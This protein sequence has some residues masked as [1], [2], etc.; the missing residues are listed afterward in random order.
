MIALTGMILEAVV[1]VLLVVTIAYCIMLD[2]R[3][4]AFKSE[5]VNL[6]GLV[7]ELSDATSNA[8]LA[9]AGLKN[10]ADEADGELDG[11]LKKARSLS[12]ELAFM[13]E[14]GNSLA[15]KLADPARRGG[16]EPLM[17]ARK[18]AQPRESQPVR[19]NVAY[20]KS[21]KRRGPAEK[22]EPAFAN[23][24][25]PAAD[26]PLHEDV[27]RP[28]KTAPMRPRTQ[29]APAAG[30]QNGLA[31]EPARPLAGRPLHAPAAAD[32]AMAPRAQETGEPDFVSAHEARRTLAQALKYAR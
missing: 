9:V 14:T 27:Q 12:E 7:A 11:K 13:V 6:A 32:R 25:R 5:Q 19:D 17:P 22:T 23:P 30:G 3:I 24:V 1:A 2:R 18:P 29:S 8:Q 10:T 4:R 28:V 15:G 16:S 21:S 20:L 31:R 26:T